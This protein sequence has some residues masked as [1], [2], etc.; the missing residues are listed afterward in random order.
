ML[1]VEDFVFIL[2]F[3]M[4]SDLHFA[5]HEWWQVLYSVVVAWRQV[6]Q[7]VLYSAFF[8]FSLINHGMDNALLA[9]VILQLFFL[10]I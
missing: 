4:F 8:S 10:R 6:Q 2:A 1:C 9:D 3:A 7:V 5:A